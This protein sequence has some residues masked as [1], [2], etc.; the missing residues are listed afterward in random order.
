MLTIVKRPRANGS[1]AY[2]ALVRVK[3][4]GKIVYSETRTFDREKLAKLMSHGFFML[5]L[6]NWVT[7]R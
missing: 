2:L 4:K 5:L 6:K 7:I 1:V 3:R